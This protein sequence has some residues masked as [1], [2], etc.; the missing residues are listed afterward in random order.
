VDIGRI[1]RIIEIKRMD[2]VVPVREPQPTP[3]LDPESV[4]V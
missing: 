1:E 4:P 3:P 2:E